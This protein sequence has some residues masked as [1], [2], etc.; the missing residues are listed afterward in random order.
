MPNADDDTIL[1]QRLGSWR[2]GY[3]EPLIWFPRSNKTLAIGAS[4]APPMPMK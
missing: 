3:I 4:P 1:L 2:K